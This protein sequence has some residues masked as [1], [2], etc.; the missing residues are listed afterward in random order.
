[1]KTDNKEEQWG[2]EEIKKDADAPVYALEKGA[3]CCPKGAEVE[4]MEACGKILHTIA[5]HLGFGSEAEELG[6]NGTNENIPPGCS[7]KVWP[8]GKT[9]RGHWNSAETGKAR[10]NMIQ[11]CN[12][13][14]GPDDGTDE[15]KGAEDEKGS[16]AEACTAAGESCAESKCCTDTYHKCFQKEDGWASCNA[17]C[18]KKM[19][20]VDNKWA[21]QEEDV[22]D[23]TELVSN[24]NNSTPAKTAQ[25]V[26]V[27]DGENCMLSKCC[28]N[29]EHTC[30]KK[31]D[32]W[33]SCNE[34]CSS[35]Y[36]WEADGWVDKG[37]KVWE[38]DELAHDD[39]ESEKSFCDMSECDA[40]E[41]A[42]CTSCA[43]EKTRDCCLADLCKTLEGDELT[44]CQG[45]N[46]QTC[47]EGKSGHCTSSA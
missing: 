8:G 36:G 9:G 45:Q 19:K 3:C 1:M 22:W 12:T 40:C 46:L 42:Q 10:E 14:T 44:S 37:K 7:F 24:A 18:S 6:W 41:G 2:C 25:D 32:H 5:V 17:T 38:C 34:T 13:S 16:Q 47:C 28:S 27:K 33:A 30:Y 20:W 21:E 43:E 11:I 23:C 4:S 39:S 29:S 26:C 31:D 35:N 15:E